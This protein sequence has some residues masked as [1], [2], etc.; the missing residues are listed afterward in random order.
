MNKQ[1]RLLATLLAIALATQ[2]ARAS[3]DASFDVRAAAGYQHDSNVSITE[4]DTNTGEADN[5]TLLELDL[6]AK[7]ALSDSVSLNGGYSYSQ[8]NYST[9][10]EFDTAIHS[11]RGEVAWRVA[12]FDTSLALRH[13]AATLDNERFLDIRQVSP[14]IARLFGRTLYVRTA[15]T[16]SDKSYAGREERDADNSAVNVDAYWLLDGMNRY[17]AVGYR[18]DSEDAQ[19]DELDFDGNRFKA[20][21]AQSLDTLPLT[22]KAQWQIEHRDYDN[23]T[24]SIGD[25]RRDRRMRTSLNADWQFAEHV[26]LEGEAA[27]ADYRSNLPGA[28][29]DEVIYSLS[30]A[31]SF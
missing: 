3:D 28:Q 7:A 17:L 22:M 9:F 6:N 1:T 11:L 21:Y 5:A 12:G 19:D 26:G 16:D 18:L 24:E 15:F 4:L 31:A 23:V 25:A 2:A 14:S 13:F 8:T 10:G 29:F 20:T 30:L 27:Y